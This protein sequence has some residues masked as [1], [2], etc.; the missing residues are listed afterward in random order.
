MTSQQGF[1]RE[2]RG[3]AVVVCLLLLVSASCVSTPDSTVTQPPTQDAQALLR[4][5]ASR[6]LALESL[7]FVLEHQAG[8]TELF[9]GVGM[10]K[11][12]GVVDIPDKFSISLEAQMAK[13]RAYVELSAIRVGDRAYMTDLITGR[14]RQVEL[15]TVPV[16][17]GNLGETLADIVAAVQSPESVGVETLAGYKT[18]RIRGQILSQE[19]AQL[20]PRAAQGF[21]VGLDLWGEA[22]QGLVVQALITGR[23][24]ATD[25]A[26]AARLLTFDGFDDPVDIGPPQ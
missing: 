23:V 3:S 6:M 22:S 25:V 14:W 9:P 17:L 5:A 2:T 19:L 12:T 15:A 26:E 16:N 1:S 18:V 20:I 8:S 7:S 13:P 24:M 10:T 4:R 11:A 21:N